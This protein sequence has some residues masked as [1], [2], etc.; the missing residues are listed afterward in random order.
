MYYR[1]N[2]EAVKS[3]LLSRIFRS[4]EKEGFYLHFILPFW[5]TLQRYIALCFKSLFSC[6]EI[7][8][9]ELKSK[10][11]NHIRG[12]VIHIGLRNLQEEGIPGKSRILIEGIKSPKNHNFLTSIAKILKLLIT[13][14]KKNLK[15]S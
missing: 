4:A 1:G 10:P 2:L 14:L 5:L 13:Q 15:N 8:H 12:E 11:I 7:K 3:H 9:S 6:F